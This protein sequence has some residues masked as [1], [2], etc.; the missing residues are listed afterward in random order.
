MDNG[1][2]IEKTRDCVKHS[3]KGDVGHDWFHIE[4]VWT[5]AKKIA[6]EEKADMFIVEMAA[7]LHDLDDFKFNDGDGAAVKSKAWLESL[8]VDGVIIDKIIHIVEN[9]SFKGSAEK[10][11][12]QT[13][14]GKVVQDADRL[15]ALGAIGVARAFT[16]AGHANMCIYDPAVKVRENMK[17]SEYK[18]HESSA[19]N[20]FYEKLLLLKERMNTKTGKRLAE[21]RHKFMEQYLE[22][23][24]KE[25]RR[26][27]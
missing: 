27:L 24:F 8:G 26:E 19:V 11:K 17:F 7:L 6:E 16:F 5:M 15:D 21:G 4:R 10:E 9:V 13:L 23:F 12:I 3:C 22:Q 1:H 14:E 2:I 25:A 18:N 20:H